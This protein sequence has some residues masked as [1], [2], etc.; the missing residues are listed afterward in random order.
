MR[1]IWFAAF[2]LLALIAFWPTYLSRIGAS[3]A[4]THLHAVTAVLWMMMLV[5]QPA[6]IR[7]RRLDLHRGLGKI[8]FGLVPLIVLSV[9]L[10]RRRPGTTSSSR[11][12][13]PTCSSSA[14]FPLT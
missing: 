1:R 9:V 11:S 14:S 5:A 6:A 4:Y 8:S 13:S 2:L 12:A 7:A 10:L 3:T